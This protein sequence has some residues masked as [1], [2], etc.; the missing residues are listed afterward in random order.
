MKEIINVV[1]F[2]PAFTNWGIAI[3]TI[4]IATGTITPSHLQ[5]IT[6]TPAR[7]VLKATDRLRRAQ[8]IKTQ[9]LDLVQIKPQVIFS[10]IPTGSQSAVAA[11][12]LGIT[13]GLLASMSTPIIQILPHETKL[14]TG[15]TK[16]ASKD[17]MIKWA[18]TLYP[19]LNWPTS[20][21]TVLKKAEH[22]ADALAVIH[23]G[24]KSDQFKQLLTLYREK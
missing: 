17:A 14:A 1:G 12:G 24:V 5:L 9:L 13:T 23:A 4:E 7:N 21:T 2:D 20:G 11:F 22:L 19:S 15:L 6:T 18:T 8:Y 16:N 3:A 10:E